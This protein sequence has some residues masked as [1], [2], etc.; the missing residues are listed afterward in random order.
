MSLSHPEAYSKPPHRLQL[1]GGQMEV[2]ESTTLL[3]VR[4]SPY[5]KPIKMKS[6]RTITQIREKGKAQKTS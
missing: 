2:R 4:R 5:H 3:S 1:H 6:W